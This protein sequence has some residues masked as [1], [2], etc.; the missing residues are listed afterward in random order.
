[1]KGQPALRCAVS[2]PN[3]AKIGR[4]NVDVLARI[5]VAKAGLAASI[6]FLSVPPALRIRLASLM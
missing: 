6:Y 3:R 2:S 1:M 5:D 4:T